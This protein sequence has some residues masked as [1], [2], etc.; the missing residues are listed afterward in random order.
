MEQEKLELKLEQIM[1]KLSDIHVD[2]QLNKQEVE[3]NTEK[4]KDHEERLRSSERFQWRLAG[5]GAVFTAV[6]AWIKYKH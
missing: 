3:E 4:L 2:L 6:S 5:A 1:N